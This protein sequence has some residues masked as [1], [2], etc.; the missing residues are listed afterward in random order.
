M[1]LLRLDIDSGSFSK[2]LITL[3]NCGLKNNW[4][5]DQDK[6]CRQVYRGTCSMLFLPVWSRFFHMITKRAEEL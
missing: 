2:E 5:N 3:Y 6:V 4:V 1:K